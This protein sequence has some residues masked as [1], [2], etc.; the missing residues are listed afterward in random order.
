[1]Y[2]QF[3]LWHGRDNNDFQHCIIIP[4]TIRV[5]KKETRDY[6]Y[7]LRHCSHVQRP[8]RTWGNV[9]GHARVIRRREDYCRISASLIKQSTIH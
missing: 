7:I 8:N 4:T 5:I 3:F 1:M 9:S 2:V 6:V